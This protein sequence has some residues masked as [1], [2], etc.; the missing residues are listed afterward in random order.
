[1]VKILNISEG[2]TIALHAALLLSKGNGEPITTSEAAETMK[3]SAAHLSKVLQRLAKA[4]IV[5]AVRGPK[6]G[7]LLGRPLS[8]IRLLDVLEAV[9]GPLKLNR[10]LLAVPRCGNDGCMLGNLLDTINTQVLQH[11]EKRLYALA[12]LCRNRQSYRLA[13]P[14]FRGQAYLRKL[15]LDLF[16][17]GTGEITLIHRDDYLHSCRSR[18]V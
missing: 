3:V 2:S 8:E 16:D 17:I 12:G 18:V 13:A 6:G 10:C 9:E 11:F 4:G 5:H 1:M 14:V 7:Y 15:A